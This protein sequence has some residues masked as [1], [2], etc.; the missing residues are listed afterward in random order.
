MK[1]TDELFSSF[2]QTAKKI[3]KGQTLKQAHYEIVFE[4][5]KDFERFLKNIGLLM[6][7]LNQRP[8][9][10][11]Q[12]AKLTNRDISNIKKVISFFEGIGAIRLEERT[13]SGR[14]V[15][16]PIVDYDRIEFDLK[17]A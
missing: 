12:L 1:S 9:S 14:K 11:Y 13:I 4:V 5:K 3:K 10:I 16:K 7:I 15:K 17:A 6:A 2:D 8:H